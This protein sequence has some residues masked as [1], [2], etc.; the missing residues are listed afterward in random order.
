MLMLCSS[1]RGECDVKQ[2]VV[3]AGSRAPV[4]VMHC[5]STDLGV[6]KFMLEFSEYS[7]EFK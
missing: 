4:C 3:S 7:R 2:G 5:S 6:G 1:R